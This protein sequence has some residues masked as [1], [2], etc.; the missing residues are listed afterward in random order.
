[1]IVIKKNRP[2]TNLV[3][4]GNIIEGLKKFMAIEKLKE[5]IDLLKV[6][7]S[8]RFKKYEKIVNLK[9]MWILKSKI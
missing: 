9:I 5:K 8:L 4:L 6:L 2:R 7:E 1:M 3:S